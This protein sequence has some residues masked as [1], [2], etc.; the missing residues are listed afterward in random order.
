MLL[1]ADRCWDRL[2]HWGWRSQSSSWLQK[3]ELQGGS[4]SASLSLR[5]SL[6]LG[7]RPSPINYGADVLSTRRS[8]SFVISRTLLKKEHFLS[9][10]HRQCERSFISR[11]YG[12]KCRAKRRRF[13]GRSR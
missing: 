3:K 9:A 2:Q 4:L 1:P 11:S 7:Q 5:L 6:A 13:S 12:A 8:P 10:R